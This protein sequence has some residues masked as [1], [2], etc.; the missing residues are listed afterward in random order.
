MA[1]VS[2]DRDFAALAA[3]FGPPPGVILLSRGNT[4]TAYLKATLGGQLMQALTPIRAG[5]T[6]V[7][8]GGAR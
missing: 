4:S 7:E 5:E 3:R 8:I 1:L 6:L 2:K